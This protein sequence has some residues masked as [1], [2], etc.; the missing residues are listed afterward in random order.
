M[1]PVLYDDIGV[2][3]NIWEEMLEFLYTPSKLTIYIYIWIALEKWCLGDDPF[4][5]RGKLG[6]FSAANLL[7][8][9]GYIP[10]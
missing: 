7:L 3:F 1:T 5:L 6:L 8:V 9:S 2:C 4:S 10:Y